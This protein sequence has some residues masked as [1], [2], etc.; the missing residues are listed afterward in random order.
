VEPIPAYIPCHPK[1]VPTLPSCVAGLRRHP[2]VGEISV[3]AP[4]SVKPECERLGVRHV[5]ELEVIDPWFDPS[6]P[7]GDLRWYYAM[8]LKLGVAFMEDAPGRYLIIDCDTVLLHPMPLIDEESGAALHP[9]MS[10]HVVPYYTGMAELFGHEVTYDGSYVAHFMVFR[11]SVVRRMFEEFARVAGRPP[12]DGRAV[13][14]EF[15][16]GLDRETRSFADYETYGYY[17]A[18]HAPGEIE[19]VER[20]Q[21]NVLYVKPSEPVFERLRRHYDYASFHAYRRPDNPFVRFA[22]WAWLNLRMARDRLA[23]RGPVSVTA[24]REAEPS[25]SA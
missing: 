15:L 3:V 1:D 5:D 11:S 25:P 24:A 13:L 7:Y 10:E 8:F 12:E 4:A 9:R 17:A 22:G 18:E 14:R 6:T 16:S 23:R 2:Q 21:L 19:W 20:Q